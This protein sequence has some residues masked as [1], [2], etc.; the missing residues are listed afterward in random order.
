MSALIEH[1]FSGIKVGVGFALR[2]YKIN[3]LVLHE[4][5]LYDKPYCT[6]L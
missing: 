3:R 2:F 5:I 4:C 6:N 1:F